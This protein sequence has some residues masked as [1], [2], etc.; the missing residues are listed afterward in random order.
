[1]MKFNLLEMT[2]GGMPAAAPCAYRRP[3]RPP[4]AL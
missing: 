2:I 1:M 3:A 4:G